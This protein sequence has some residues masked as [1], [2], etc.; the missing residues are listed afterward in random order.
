[1]ITQNNVDTDIFSIAPDAFD[2]IDV[3]TANE[4]RPGHR[5]EGL[6]GGRPE[7]EPNGVI[8]RFINQANI[9]NNQEER[10]RAALGLVRGPLPEVETKWLHRYYDYL[11]ENLS[12][13]FEA[14]YAEDIAGYRQVVSPIAVVAL[15]H[16]DDHGRH[17]EFGLLCRAKRG[18]QTLELPLA[19]V[20]LT[21]NSPNSRLIDDYWYWFW[22]WRFDPK[23]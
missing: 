12:L 1:M 18:G 2:A 15:L 10:I 21:D 23:I 6:V 3:C 5:P 22:N 11:V 16:P 14:E 7:K 13:P 4:P 9:N 8:C 20:E 19:D 17:E